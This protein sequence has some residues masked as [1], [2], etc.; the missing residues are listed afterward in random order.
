MNPTQLQTTLAPLVALGAGW[1]A[2][3]FGIS[4]SFWTEILTWL[5]GG[6]SIL[7]A[8]FATT[9]TALITTVANAPE[10][11]S[12]KLTAAAPDA[13]KDKTPDNVN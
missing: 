4:V 6:G 2:G 11:A 9:K 5:V 1:L 8:A 3:R 10:V 7:W 13:M 12:V